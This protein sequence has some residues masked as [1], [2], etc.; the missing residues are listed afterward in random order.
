MHGV[1]HVPAHNHVAIA[2][3]I[4]AMLV[5]RVSLPMMMFSPMHKQ[6]SAGQ[7][8]WQTHPSAGTH[9]S[10]GSMQKANF[11]DEFKGNLLA[12]LATTLIRC[13]TVN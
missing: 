2:A 1:R 8:A 9:G 3:R 7:G 4:C 13:Q 11:C 6:Q 12:L 10:V 5:G